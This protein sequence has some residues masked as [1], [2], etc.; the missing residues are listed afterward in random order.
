MLEH[1]FLQNLLHFRMRYQ[2]EGVDVRQVCVGI[3][4]A[5]LLDGV[6]QL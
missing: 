2:F 5:F 6:L 4:K 1:F 3:P